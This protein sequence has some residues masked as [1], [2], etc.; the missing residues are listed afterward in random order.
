MD[1]SPAPHPMVQIFEEF[2]TGT[3]P[4]LASTL[5]RS[6][7]I[8]SEKDT[9]KWLPCPEGNDLDI[10][11]RK[12][13][14]N[15]IVFLSEVYKKESPNFKSDFQEEFW[16]VLEKD[17]NGSFHCEYGCSESRVW[18]EASWSCFKVKEVKAADDYKWKQ[19][20]IHVTWDAATGR[21]LVYVFEFKQR[22]EQSFLKAVPTAAERRCNPFPWHAVFARIILEQYD[23]AFWLLRDL[24]RGQ[25]KERSKEPDF[26]LLHDILR[27]LF[28]YQETIEVA[29]HT[30]RVMAEEQLRWRIEDGDEVRKNLSTWMKTRQRFLYEEKRAHSLKMRSKSLN[31]RHENEI[32]L[33][34]NEVSQGFGHAARSDSRM[35]TTVAVVSMVYL[36]GTFVSGLFGTN[37]FSFQADPG[38]TWL[39]ADEF[40]IYWAVTVPLTLATMGVWALWHWREK[41]IPWWQKA[42]GKAVGI[43]KQEKHRQKTRATRS[44]AGNGNGPI[45]K[46][47]PMSPVKRMT[48]FFR[49]NEVQRHETV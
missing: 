44:P 3:A 32:N 1:H 48:T 30:L 43:G 39:T 49:L 15:L 10:V 9:G 31:D 26:P 35:M 4:A 34:F 8:D 6:L 14:S 16:P 20:T 36:P 2:G 37:F 45:E 7:T 21:Q 42:T 25:E 27:H 12:P 19:P 5:I 22:Q 24:V 33:A 18:P 13:D 46:Q 17:I 40:W 29:Q 28:H 41:Y 47:A 23:D 11:K 38:N